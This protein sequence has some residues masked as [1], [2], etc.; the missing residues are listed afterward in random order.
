MTRDDAPDL[1]RAFVIGHPIGHSRSPALHGHWLARHRIAGRYEAIDVAPGDLGRFIAD[2]RQNGYAGGN[3]TLPHK[4]SVAAL[5]D[6][7]DIA[8]VQIGA[9]NTLWFDD[10]RLIGGNTDGHGFVA[11]LDDRAAGWDRAG[12]NATA[13]IL[14]AGGAARAVAVALAQRGIGRIVIT[15]RTIER[16]DAICS[17]CRSLFPGTVFEASPWEERSCL[18][19]GTDLVVN[20]TSLGMAGQPPLDLALDRLG[21]AAVVNDLVYNPL[22]SGLLAGARARGNRIVDGLGMLLHQAAPGFARWFGITPA[23][24]DELRNA[25]LNP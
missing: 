24:D 18:L 4:E 13:L 22:E 9:V 17:H 8:A 11:N 21:P 20:T 19:A 12:S 16:A 23:V 7:Q 14:G 6:E 15:N 3:V 25:V 10:G 5:V 1:E 2:L